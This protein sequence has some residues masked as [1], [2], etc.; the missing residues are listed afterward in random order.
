MKKYKRMC[1][2]ISALLVLCLAM[3]SVAY[4]SYNAN[5]VGIEIS[6]NDSTIQKN[7]EDAMRK[8]SGLT[9]EEICK[10]LVHEYGFS[11]EEV[12]LL[13]SAYNTNNNISTYSFPSNPTIGQTYGWKV[14]PIT[15]PSD[16]D[17][18]KIAIIN[19]IAAAAVPSFA[20]V[21][22]IVTAMVGSLPAGKTVTVIINYT[23]GYN[24]DG[25]LG[26]TPGYIDIQVQ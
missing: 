13:Y 17:K 6:F 20:A 24:N 4:A 25:V 16:Q 12:K 14:G 5:S 7:Y 22:A 15:L 23:Y 10:L 18:A 2:L 21:A 19:A 9:D 8:F 3:H 11:E 1:S 26:W